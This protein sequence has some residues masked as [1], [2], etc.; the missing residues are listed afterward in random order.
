MEDDQGPAGDTYIS[1]Y[2]PHKARLACSLPK[3]SPRKGLWVYSKENKLVAKKLIG[4]QIKPLLS[5]G[6]A[7]KRTHKPQ[8]IFVKSSF[9][10]RT[11]AFP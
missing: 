6:S 11:P 10:L 2:N 8:Q 5:S 9:P 4:N 3:V 1:L 7:N